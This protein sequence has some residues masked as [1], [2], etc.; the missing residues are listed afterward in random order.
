ML[1][2]RK[3]KILFIETKC[4]Q[5]PPLLPVHSFS[6]VA[7]FQEL[8]AS[9]LL[10]DLYVFEPFSA[11]SLIFFEYFH[12]SYPVKIPP[13][14]KAHPASFSA[15]LLKEK[16]TSVLGIPTDSDGT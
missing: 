2:G 14:K 13:L 6:E 8:R 7:V 5:Y 10:P 3:K 15:V 12:F 16:V 9:W 1:R 11:K 4:G